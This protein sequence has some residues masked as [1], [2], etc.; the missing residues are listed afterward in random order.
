MGHTTT[1]EV[2][3][4]EEDHSY[5][6]QEGK[7]YTSCTTL[8][9]LFHEKFNSKKV[10][11][12]YAYKMG[13]QTT[14]PDYSPEWKKPQYWIDKW[15]AN[16]LEATTR[17]SAFHL[18]RELLDLAKSGQ[19]SSNREGYNYS[20]DLSL[21]PNGL[22]CELLLHDHYWEVAGQAD[23]IILEED[24]FLVEDYKTNKEIKL[25]SWCKETPTTLSQLGLGEPHRE[26]KMMYFPVNHL[27]DTNYNHYALQ[28]S[29]YAYMVEKATG[30]P[31]KGLTLLHHKPLSETEVDPVAVEYEVPYL[32]DE[33]ELL[34]QYHFNKPLPNEY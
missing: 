6:N 17:G 3:F 30:K 27:M 15:E 9:G 12:A 11:T 34:L 16:T 28:L 24:G 19:T 2:T 8:I 14:H 33:V 29:L 10:A 22:H 32:K 20:Q 4:R 23:R 18:V 5:T 7:R 1:P 21:L 25:V 13:K 31:C 26:Y